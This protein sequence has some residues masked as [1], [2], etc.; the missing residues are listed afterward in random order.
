VDLSPQSD[1]PGVDALR[2]GRERLHVR[3]IGPGRAILGT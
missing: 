2:A 3:I 1:G